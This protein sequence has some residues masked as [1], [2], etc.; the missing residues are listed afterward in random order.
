LIVFAD[1]TGEGKYGKYNAKGVAE[2]IAEFDLTR[3]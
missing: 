2:L 3:K 1:G